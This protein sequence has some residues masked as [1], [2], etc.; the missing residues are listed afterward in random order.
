M[1][2]SIQ[3]IPEQGELILATVAQITPHGVYV[4]LDEY[5][6]MPGFLHISEISTGRVRNIHRFTKEGQKLVLKVIRVGKLRKE[7]DLS[8]RQVTG[9]EK[10]AKL[11]EVKKSEKAF[12]IFD[13]VMNKL[14]LRKEEDDQYKNVILHEFDGLYDAAEEIVRKGS[15]VLEKLNLPPNYVS[16]LEQISKEKIILPIVTVKGVIEATCKQP[17]GIDIIKEALSAAEKIKTGGS[18]VT[19]M[20]MGTPRFRITVSAENY[21]IAEKVL[22]AATEKVQDILDKHDSTFS[23]TRGVEKKGLE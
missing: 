20:Y 23:F 10:K 19:V 6:R 1:A 15:K 5:D 17:N 13:T 9:E 2:E 18:E 7:V 21:K 12:N 14:N 22:E 8:L 4:T 3:E 11:I 16:T